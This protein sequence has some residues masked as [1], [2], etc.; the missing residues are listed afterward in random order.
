MACMIT[1]SLCTACS[2]SDLSWWPTAGTSQSASGEESQ[3]TSLGLT[4]DLDYDRPVIEAHIEVDQLGYL[5]ESPKLVIFRGEDLE[6]DFHVVSAE[7]GDT[8]YTGKIRSKTEA[9]S[10]ETFY[11]GEFTDLTTP[12]TYYVQTDVIGYS[13]PF[14]I[15]EDIYDDVLSVALKQYYLNRCGVSL[16]EKYA[17][18]A[19]R[20]ACHT[21]PI[22]LQQPA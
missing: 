22:T 13:Y 17:G 21:D 14:S 20:S 10:G 5:L 4:P 3:I 16:T 9:I 15:G 19:A 12:G 11:Y 18:D 8:V 6:S 7:S 1:A 2:P